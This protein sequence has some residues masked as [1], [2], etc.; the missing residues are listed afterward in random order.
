MTLVL[1]KLKNGKAPFS[2]NFLSGMLKMAMNDGESGYMV[3][4]LVKAV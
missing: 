4:D 2:S 3:L 1:T